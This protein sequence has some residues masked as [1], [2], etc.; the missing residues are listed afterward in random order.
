[1]DWRG[2]HAQNR[3]VPPSPHPGG[4]PGANRKSISHRCYLFEAAFEWEL[5]KE[6]IYL[7]LGCFK[8]GVA[9]PGKAPI[10]ASGGKEFNRHAAVRV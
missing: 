7:P 4:N 8:G 2:R 5:T 3:V 10:S 9:N 6:T 1:M